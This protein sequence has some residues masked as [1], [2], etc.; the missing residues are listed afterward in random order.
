[1]TRLAEIIRKIIITKV[2]LLMDV[3]WVKIVKNIRTN[4]GN[5][6]KIG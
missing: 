5:D 6:I 3:R 4:Y 2:I 1:M